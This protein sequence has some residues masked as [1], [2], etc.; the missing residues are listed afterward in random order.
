MS[1][2]I[3]MLIRNFANLSK[4][5]LCFC[6]SVKADGQK[7]YKNFSKKFGNFKLSALKVTE[8]GKLPA[9]EEKGGVK[10]DKEESEFE[11]R[12]RFNA[13]CKKT[14]RNELISSMREYKNQRRRE[15]SF[16]DLTPKEEKQ[17]Y[18]VDRYFDDEDDDAFY[19][20]GLKISEK[21]LNE[22]LEILPKEKLQAVVLHYFYN[23]SDS[24][25]AKLI[26]VSRSTVQYRRTSSF[27]RL[28]RFLEERADEW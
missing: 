26:N 17:L 6:P 28:K 22:A 9:P 21:L 14:L 27:E 19:I 2:F 25:I 20:Q 10:M 8:R 16:E 1:F 11:A 12:C 5:V 7:F 13:Y 18:T 15:V 4:A 23:M 3:T 24:D